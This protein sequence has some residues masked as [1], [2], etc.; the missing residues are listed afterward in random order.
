MTSPK[1]RKTTIFWLLC[2][3]FAIFPVLIHSQDA[4][5]GTRKLLNRRAPR[6]PEIARKMNLTGIV[7]IEAVVAPNGTVKSVVVVGGHPLLAQ[8]AEDAIRDWKWEPASHETHE[9]IE[10]KFDK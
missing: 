2:G 5:E 3:I 6:Y 10:V 7:K 1:W 9:L 8:V 4:N